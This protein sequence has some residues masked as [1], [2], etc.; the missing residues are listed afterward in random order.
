M[1]TANQNEKGT[2]MKTVKKILSV[3]LAILLDPFGGAMCE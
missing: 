2:A 3:V 1:M